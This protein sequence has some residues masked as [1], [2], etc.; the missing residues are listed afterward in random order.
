MAQIPAR[1]ERAMCRPIRNLTQMRGFDITTH[2]CMLGGA[3]AEACAIAV[4]GIGTGVR[5]PYS[6][7]LSAYGLSRADMA[8]AQES[9]IGRNAAS[10][11]MKATASWMKTIVAR[12]RRAS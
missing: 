5:A 2:V 3:R 7:V 11:R 4:P 10:W 12:T 8:E 1:R 9:R 6:G